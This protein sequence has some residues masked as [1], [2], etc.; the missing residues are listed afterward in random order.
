MSVDESF[1]SG[2]VF[3]DWEGIPVAVVPEPDGGKRGWAFDPTKRPFNPATALLHGTRITEAE[4]RAK[5]RS[6]TG[7]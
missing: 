5:A 4:F 3:Y 7:R 2:T 6:H 1:P